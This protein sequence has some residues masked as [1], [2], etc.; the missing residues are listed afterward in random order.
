MRLVF[1]RR[2]ER[3]ASRGVVSEH[4]TVYVERRLQCGRARE[5]FMYAPLQRH[6]R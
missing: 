6:R 1:Q 2:A 3:N 4:Y 5:G